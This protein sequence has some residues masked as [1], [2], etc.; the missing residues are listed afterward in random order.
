[1]PSSLMDLLLTDDIQPG[2]EP[3][4]QTC[5]TIY[6]AH[7]LGGKMAESPIKLAQSQP[8]DITIED[9]P[10]KELKEAF[11]A[12][13]KSIGG[14]GADVVIRNTLTLSRVYGI[15]SL[16]IIEDGVET[17]TPLQL[18]DLAGKSI[19]FNVLDPLNT[20]GSLI[21]DQNPNSSQ[22]MKPT[23]VTVGAKTYHTSRAV[24]VMNEQPVYIEW[25]NS[26]FGF[27]GRSVYQRALYPLKS[28]IQTMITDNAVTEKA[29]LL[30]AKM[31]APG[32]IIDQ[33]ARTWFG[34]KRNAIKGAKTGNVVSIGI[35]ESIES[36]DLKNLRDAAEFARNNIL[37]NIA[38]A[39]DMPASLINQET[40]A[41]GFGEGSE[42][43]KI[44]ARYIDG[45]RID[46][47]PVYAFMDAI[48]M[49][50]AWNKD[51]YASLQAKYPAKYKDVPFET[52]FYAW[53]NSFKA[54]WPNLMKEPDSEIAKGENDILKAAIGAFEVL[55]PTLDPVNRASAACWLADIINERKLLFSTHLVIDE[56]LMAQYAP[57]EVEEYENP[58]ESGR[59]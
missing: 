26:A 15:A 30:V 52:A 59:D 7:P 40:L 25:S 36:I 55:A 46:A 5:K 14:S 23:Q 27:V 29:A 19:T 38:T 6:V 24:I 58:A 20:A 16:A 2:S 8:R 41:E 39:A 56:D 12:E 34:F 47:Q 49:H 51:F 45:V 31:K 18:A 28:F 21:L 17:N 53:K 10:E 32:S 22:F 1:M 42:D 43:A 50:R 9:A 4:Y 35:D 44:I 13:W 37:K 48:V 11:D 3:G 57:E 54:E 33:Q